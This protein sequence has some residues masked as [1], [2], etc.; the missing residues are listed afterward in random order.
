MTLMH[1]YDRTCQGQKAFTP[2]PCRCKTP[3]HV[4]D[5]HPPLSYMFKTFTLPDGTC[6][7]HPPYFTMHVQDTVHHDLACIGHYVIHLTQ[8]IIGRSIYT[9]LNTASRPAAEPCKIPQLPDLQGH[10]LNHSES[11][12]NPTQLVQGSEISPSHSGDHPQ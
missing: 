9:I 1:H 10:L 2:P 7:G 11:H 12:P 6:A 3:V 4:Q 8:S 5:T